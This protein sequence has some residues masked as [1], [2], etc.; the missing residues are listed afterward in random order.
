MCFCACRFGVRCNAVLP[1]FIQTPMT[2]HVPEKVLEN[3]RSKLGFAITA[4]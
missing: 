2:E 1:G 3:V 4:W